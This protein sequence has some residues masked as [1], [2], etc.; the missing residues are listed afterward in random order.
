MS[1]PVRLPRW[2]FETKPY[3][4]AL[5]RDEL[6]YQTCESC[7]EVI[8]FPRAVCPYCLGDKVAWHKSKGEGKVYSFT[9]QHYPG[10]PAPP[11]VLGI[12]ELDEGYYMFTQFLPPNVDDIAIGTLVSVVFDRVSPELVLPKFKLSETRPDGQPSSVNLSNS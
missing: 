10:P 9:V 6:L 2:S 4:D 12:V 11:I 8:F 3:W 7:A 5:H 1:V